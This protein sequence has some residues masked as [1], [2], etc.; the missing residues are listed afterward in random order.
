MAFIRLYCRHTTDTQGVCDLVTRETRT[1]L[2][3]TEMKV[4]RRTRSLVKNR[5]KYHVWHS[6]RRIAVTTGEREREK[7]RGKDGEKVG[8]RGRKMGE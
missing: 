7:G 5:T 3:T 2:A 6:L 4:T 8:G 1:V